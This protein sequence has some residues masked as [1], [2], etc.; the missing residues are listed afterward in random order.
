MTTT[1]SR[2]VGHSVRDLLPR[3][4]RMFPHCFKISALLPLPSPFCLERLKFQ[5]NCLLLQKE[6]FPISLE[7]KGFFLH[8]PISRVGWFSFLSSFSAHEKSN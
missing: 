1:H 7:I 4:P 6:F 2:E 3:V 5:G 8:C